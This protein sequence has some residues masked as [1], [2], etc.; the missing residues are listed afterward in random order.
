M[1]CLQEA[2][3]NSKKRHERSRSHY[4]EWETDIIAYLN[5]Q[6]CT[7][8]PFIWHSQKQLCEALN[9]PQSSLNEVIK[10]SHQLVLVRKGKGR[11]AKTGWT[12]VTRYVNYVR[13]QAQKLSAEKVLCVFHYGHLLLKQILSRQKLAQNSLKHSINLH[14]INYQSLWV[15]LAN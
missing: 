10:K 14:H 8:G 2:G 12:T 1:N 4:T 11:G 6:K 13:T 3:T 7:N 5:A 15:T 9:M